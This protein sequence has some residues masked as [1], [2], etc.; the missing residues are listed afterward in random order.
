M[1]YQ[2]VVRAGDLPPYKGRKGDLMLAFINLSSALCNTLKIE[3]A[4]VEKAV[5]EQGFFKVTTDDY[6]T[7][8]IRPVK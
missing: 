2:A 3:Y 5:K 7:G 6:R 8:T 1:K 4:E